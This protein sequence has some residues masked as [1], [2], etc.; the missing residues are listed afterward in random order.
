MAYKEELATLHASNTIILQALHDLSAHRPQSA[1][2]ALAEPDLPNS[3]GLP[4]A[5][6]G[7]YISVTFSSDINLGPIRMIPVN[8]PSFDHFSPAVL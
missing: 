1:L 2:T 3:T 7:F 8:V 5:A 4:I 6:E